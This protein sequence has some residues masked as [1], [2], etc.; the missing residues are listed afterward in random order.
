MNPG[1]ADIYAFRADITPLTIRRGAQFWFSVLGDSGE[2]S[3]S[4]RWRFQQADT[5]SSCDVQDLDRD[6]SEMIFDWTDGGS[7]GSGGSGEALKN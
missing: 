6:I 7:G 1:G 5:I 2:E 4:F 3:G